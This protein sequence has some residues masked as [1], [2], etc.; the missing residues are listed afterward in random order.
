[1]ELVVVIALLWMEELISVDDIF[2]LLRME[3]LVSERR[4][5]SGQL[6]PQEEE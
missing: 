5:S 3:E 1:M 4:V 2:A 6:I